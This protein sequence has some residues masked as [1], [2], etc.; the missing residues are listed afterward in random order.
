MFSIGS[1]FHDAVSVSQRSRT[2]RP[3]VTACPP[4]TFTQSGSGIDHLKRRDLQVV[5]C[6]SHPRFALSFC[7][8]LEGSY[9]QY[10]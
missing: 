2:S 4:T 5:S 9:G 1:N 6:A 7:F 10:R 8:H 3:S